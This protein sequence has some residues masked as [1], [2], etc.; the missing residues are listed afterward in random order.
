[1]S[2]HSYPLT[3]VYDLIAQQ[4]MELKLKLYN[5]DESISKKRHK[6]VKNRRGGRKVQN[7]RINQRLKAE[8]AG[9]SRRRS[10]VPSKSAVAKA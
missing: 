7:Q 2:Y 1:L 4:E 8:R 9:R 5:Y 3:Q 10:K 6:N